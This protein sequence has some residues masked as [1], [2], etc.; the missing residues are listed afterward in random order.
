[1]KR[2]E[3]SVLVVGAGPVGL[4]ASILLAQQGIESLVI[5]RRDGPHRAPQAH[6]VNPR[7]L[8]IFRQMGLDM[9]TLRS[10]ATRR[11]DGSRVR[12]MTRLD[13]EDLGSLPYERQGDENLAFTPTPLLN[14][15]QHLLEPVLLEQAQ[16]A[17]GTEIR[18]RQQWETLEQDE[19]G[20]TSRIRDLATDD[21]CEVR[22]RYVL[23]ADGA[24]SRVRRA[25]GI[26]MLGPDS[27]QSFMMIH[28]EAN[29]RSVVRERPAIIYWLLDPD[30]ACTLVAHDIES[31][32]VLMQPFD[33]AKDLRDSYTPERCR[34]I[35]RAAIGRDAPAFEIKDTSAWTMTAQI[36]ERYRS[37]RVF[38]VGDSAHRF[39]PTGGM[40]MNTGVQDA[41]NLVWKLAAVDG[42]WAS[43]ALLDTYEVERRPVAQNN[44]D[45]SLNNA[46]K[47]FDVFAALGLSAD[48][49]ASRTSFR[50]AMEDSSARAALD[51]AIANQQ[52]HFDMFGLQLGFR[53]ESG[54]LVP[55]GV[56][57]PRCENPVRDFVPALRSGARLPH[58]WVVRDGRR[59]STLDLVARN[60]LTL[61]T[62]RDGAAS[63]GAASDQSAVPVTCMVEGRDFLDGDGDWARVSELDARGAVLVRPDQHVAWYAT[64]PMA[65]TTALAA[66]TL[67][68]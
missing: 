10:R 5:D 56:A 14:L 63:K 53:Y 60:G 8:E 48:L 21:F 32:W 34:E 62:G 25:L 61:I 35:V 55:D 44:T 38:L 28:F 4:T 11:E 54:A 33:P 42:G 45:Q 67:R 24:S 65:I 26:E 2:L 20:V 9:E 30:N 19:R 18:Y 23:A 16:A 58:A 17:R 59:V 43:P 15:S 66:V 40:G 49:E 1:M 37:G 27:L 64:A 3:T 51:R 52:E 47:M 46:M 13:G 36:A 6:V 50:A 31:T 39:P 41:H 7:S 29:L 12:W 57:S 68:G 22:S